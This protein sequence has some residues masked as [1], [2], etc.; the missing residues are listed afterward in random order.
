MR[1]KSESDALNRLG[2]IHS[3]TTLI[4]QLKKCKLAPIAVEK[5]LNNAGKK[6]FITDSLSTLNLE[7][8]ETEN[9]NL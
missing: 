7:R 1:S 5:S 6:H 3:R 8:I 2:L 9:R 4:E